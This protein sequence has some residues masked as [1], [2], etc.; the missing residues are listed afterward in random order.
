MNTVG[1]YFGYDEDE[2]KD[3]ALDATAIIN[4]AA[5]FIHAGTK[6]DEFFSP[7]LY[8]FWRII[9]WTDALWSDAN[10]LYF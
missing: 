1:D 2:G 9:S 6:F 3:L 10:L 7:S 5:D 8:D 4:P